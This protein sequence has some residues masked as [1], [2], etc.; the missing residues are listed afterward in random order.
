MPLPDLFGPEP[1]RLAPPPGLSEPRL[2]VRRLVIWEEPE[3]VIRDVPL[4]PGLNV[5]WTPGASS[6][7]GVGHGGGKTTFC[8]L[9][10]YCLGENSFAPPPQANA[11]FSKMPNGGVGAE[12][13]LDGETWIVFRGFSVVSPHVA[14]K[15]EALG[16][17]PP[18][19]TDGLIS[20][21]RSAL[22][23]AFISPALPLFPESIGK[24]AAWPAVLAWL[25]RD[26][27]CR[28]SHLLDWRDKDSGSNSPVRKRDSSGEDRLSVVRAT[29]RT[30][31]HEELALR[32]HEAGATLQR[33]RARAEAA[34]LLRQAQQVRSKLVSALGGDEEQVVSQMDAV[35]I[36][37]RASELHAKVTGSTAPVTLAELRAVRVELVRL[38]EQK[39]RAEAARD[40]N[41]AESRSQGVLR[42]SYRNETAELSAAARRGEAP[43]CPICR[44]PL[45]KVR[46]EGCGI[47]LTPCDLEEL[48]RR[49]D[50]QQQNIGVIDRRLVELAG[51]QGPLRLA[52][53]TAEQQFRH[54]SKR[55]ERLEASA[56]SRSKE[57]RRAEALLAD[58]ERY[59][60]LVQAYEK[61]LL[62]ETSADTNLTRFRDQ[63]SFQRSQV[64]DLVG[65]IGT[66]CRTILRSLMPEAETCD[67]QLDG[68][69]LRLDI[70]MGGSRSSA[71]LESLKVVLFDLAVLSLSIEGLTLLPA[72]LVH[73]SPRE[74][75]LDP[76][77]YANYFNFPAALEQ[78]GPSPLFQYIITTTS[79]PPQGILD[80]DRLAFK[81]HG[82]PAADRLLRMDL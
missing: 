21:L 81:V 12:V 25:T 74:A 47:S 11:M 24:E 41:E 19:Q 69:G 55:L 1:L 34:S 61:E 48:N 67:L 4:R 52:L 63:V 6:V 72:F 28:F 16:P 73:D 5:I 78:F 76:A 15:G 33:D 27:E 32:G 29:T 37:K 38:T 58:A 65:N 45:D 77:I 66:R 68:N 82:A 36:L 71:A 22:T 18:S 39:I 2:W 26:Q 50:L 51:M 59:R 62:A 43:A 56:T 3:Q 17:R 44:V 9:L 14:H 80:S 49:L 35:G 64:A 75:D 7:S 10:R 54:Q 70:R 31:R 53:A 8:R 30:L 13:R 60:D 46:A 42:E 23:D 20:T 40:A 57:Q 79:P